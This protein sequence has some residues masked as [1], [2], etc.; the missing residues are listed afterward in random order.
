VG[1]RSGLHRNFDYVGIRTFALYGPCRSP[2][3]GCLLA[4]QDKATGAASHRSPVGAGSVAAKALGSGNRLVRIS[5]QRD[6]V[7]DLS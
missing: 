6:L 5:A 7:H 1:V 4:R 2:F 3:L